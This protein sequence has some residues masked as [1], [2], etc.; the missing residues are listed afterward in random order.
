MNL[1][2]SPADPPEEGGPDRA[3]CCRSGRTRGPEVSLAELLLLGERDYV[4]SARQHVPPVRR[5][6]LRR[7]AAIATAHGRRPVLTVVTLALVMALT[8]VFINELAPQAMPEVCSTMV[9][10]LG[11]EFV[12]LFRQRRATTAVAG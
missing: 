8:L 9:L 11:T 2:A 6:W 3:S 4:A 10:V 1:V 7:V 12:L 5:E